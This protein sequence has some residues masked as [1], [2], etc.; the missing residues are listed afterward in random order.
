MSK[1]S[2][3]IEELFQICKRKGDMS[4]DNSIVKEI[5][6][7]HNFK[8]PFDLTKIDCTKGLPDMLKDEDYFIIHLGEGNHRF[9]KGINIGFH[10]FEKIPE[11]NIYEWKYRK[12]ILNEYDTSESN[13]LAV[14]SNQRIIHDYLYEDIVASP[15]VYFPHRT[16]TNM[17]YYIGSIRINAEKVQ[18]EIDLTM[19]Y[20]SN[21][22]IFEAKNGIPLDFA[23][24]QLFNPNYYYNRIKR[25]GELNIREISCCYI[26]REK[27]NNISMIRIYLY[28]F[29]D[30]NQMK[31]IKLINCAQYNLKQR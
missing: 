24:Y 30:P 5:C 15:K 31:S 4:F 25:K 11:N 9:V 8:N 21:V 1:K 23:V 3:V 6:L 18:M 22:T 16:K 2:L 19:E 29:E 7:K 27:R 13:I 12:S 20:F 10:N 26:L 17:D 14:V 28:K